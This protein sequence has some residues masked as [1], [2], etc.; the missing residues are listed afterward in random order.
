[1]KEVGWICTALDPD[2]IACDHISDRIGVPVING[3]FLEVAPAILGKYDVVTLN[4]V[5]EHVE[6]PCSML[7]RAVDV[8]NPGGF[9]YAEVPDGDGAASAGQDREEFFIE[10]HHVFSSASFCSTME[11]SGLEVHQLQRLIEASGKYTL[12]CFA[13]PRSAK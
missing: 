4:K 13:S 3:D 12:V 9:V 6:D 2:P 7:R 5:I 10:H 8:L 11:R 1:M